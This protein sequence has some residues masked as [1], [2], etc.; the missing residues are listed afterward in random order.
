M[1]RRLRRTKIVTTLGPATD[2]DNNL[3]KI[4]IAGANVVRLNFSHGSAEDHL[5]RANRTREIAARLGRHVAILGDL[6]GPKIRV[7]TFKDGKVFLNV[8]DK[9]LL[10]AALEK[11]EGNQNQVGIDYKGLP[12]DVVPGDI[13]LLDDGRV[14]LKVLKVDGL[15]VFTEVTVGGP[16]S[17]NKGIN[18]LGGGLSADALT[19]KDKQDIIT[20]A[21]IGVDYLAVSFPRTGEDLHLARRLA[22]DAGCECQ[23]V[24][25]VERAEAVAND[26]IIDEIIMASDVVM[27]ARGDLGVEIGD[28]ELVGVQKKLIRRA[29][30]LNRVVITATQ[31]MESMITNPMPTRAE[32]MDVANAVLDGTD[33]VMLSAETAAGQYPAETVASMA[34]VCLGAEKMPA[35][36][37]S[38]HRLDMVFDTVE[39]AIAM[40]TMYAANHMKGVNAII[41]MTES[42]RTARMMSRISTG[43][44]IF[45]MSRHEKTLNQT[46]LYR[47]VTPVYCSTHTDGIAAAN[48]AIARL[49]DKGFLVSGDLVLVT[50]GD[51]MG[52]IGSTNTCRIL[53]VE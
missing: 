9:F 24:S 1:S 51:L 33:A 20:A 3:E 39:E 8:G 7:S 6:Q 26:E 23:I 44:P 45:S 25:K 42:G 17:N 37:V 31:M 48:E 15:K 22:R 13:L 40:S 34:Q 53:T 38:K 35:A 5:A 47:G 10:D 50:Q 49:R 43:L 41:A 4:I 11:G 32:V 16:L 19:E 52:T 28:P 2:R 36:N 18:K 21:K 14:Q 30:Q 29:R 27:V 12:A 46:A